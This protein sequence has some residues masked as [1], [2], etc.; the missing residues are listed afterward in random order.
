M[1]M[2]RRTDIGRVR[3]LNEDSI[4]LVETKSGV[5][6][7]IV[8]DGMGGHQ[9]GDVASQNTVET[10][11]KVL[12]NQALDVST[13]EK[14]D[15][16]LHAVGK[17]N[18]KIYT[19]A[20]KNTQFQGMG[21]TVVA[22]IVD[23]REVVIAHVG[24]SRA[25]ML[26]KGGLYQL[27]EDHSYVNI[28]QKHGQITPEEARNHPQRNMIVRAVGTSEEVEVDLINTPW[29]DEDV[30]LLCSD[31]LTTMVDERQIGLVLSSST[32]SL[33]QQAD[34]LVQ[35]ALDAGGT[36]NIS[37]ILLKHTGRSAAS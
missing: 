17:A 9:A 12:S 26:H 19:L 35:M 23:E 18:E 24:D 21:T 22:A 8:A 10:V 32:M 27:T 31:G 30:L 11:K 34:Q 4:G 29:R 15:I 1:E 14:S 3:D 2:A 36:D 20:S 33:E 25:Y 16:L 37:L 13:E 6:I 5:V 7:A 28:L